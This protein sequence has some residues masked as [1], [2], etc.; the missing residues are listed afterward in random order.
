[1]TRFACLFCVLAATVFGGPGIQRVWTDSSG[2]QISA[3]FLWADEEILYL[4]LTSGKEVE[5]A[6][7]R[8]SNQ[9]LEF[10]RA[11][12]ASQKAKG[13]AFEALLTWEEF[14]SKKVTAGEARKVGA[15]PLD[16]REKTKGTLRLEF[17][18]FGGPRQVGPNQRAVLRMRSAARG[19]AGTTSAITITFRGKTI[20]TGRNVPANSTFDIPLS[21]EVFAAGNNVELTV[22]CGPD[23]VHLRTEES[24]AGP[25]LL[26]VE[27]KSE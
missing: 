27:Q 16:S 12:H 10:V 20:G 2:K 6:L 21:P 22:T 1:M 13:I 19:D 11:F 23:T 24:G 4:K 17:R 3:R 8:L 25:R 5:V 14:H 15:Y 26:I 7:G 9:D 18:R